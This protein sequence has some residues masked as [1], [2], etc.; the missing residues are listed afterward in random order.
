MLIVF[1]LDDTLIDTS[2][3]VTPFKMG[4]CLKRL[5]EKGME[6][7]NFEETYHELLTFNCDS[8]SSKEA[9]AR[10]IWKVGFPPEKAHLAFTELTAPLPA[11]FSI[12]TTPNAFDVLKHFHSRYPLAL[13]TG[14]NL[15]F[16]SDKM[17]KAGLDRSLFSKIAIPEDSVKKVVYETLS[18]EFSVPAHDIWVCGDRIEMDLKPA[19]ELGFHTIHMQWGRGKMQS[20]DWVEF[21]ISELNQLLGIIS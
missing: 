18:K 20:A 8:P 10:L 14:G 15:S 11:H 2:G 16:Q 9:L 6:V 7:K 21:R 3:S 4:E 13:V 12:P 19:K 17:E 1:D 5:I